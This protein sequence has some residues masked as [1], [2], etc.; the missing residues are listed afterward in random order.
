MVW[1]SHLSQS[2]PQFV[3]IHTVKGF[4]I[5]KKAEIDVFL[6]LPCFFHAYFVPNAGSGPWDTKKRE[7]ARKDA[8]QSR[9][10]RV[11]L[12]EIWG[13]S[14]SQEGLAQLGALARLPRVIGG[15]LHRYAHKIT[16][17]ESISWAS[18]R[19]GVWVLLYPDN[20][21]IPWNLQIPH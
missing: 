4:G 19:I 3:V 17:G 11:L 7:P 2:C 14:G 13:S 9:L 6:E 10:K 21:R 18:G 8:P 5:V 12:W 1:Y 20:F 16:Q 15:V